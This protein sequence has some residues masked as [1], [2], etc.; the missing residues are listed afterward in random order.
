MRLEIL[1]AGATLLDPWDH[2]WGGTGGMWL[3][4]GLMM[5]FWVALVA[6]V[7]WLVATRSGPSPKPPAD[8]AREILAE[9]YARGEITGEEYRERLD[10]LRPG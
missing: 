2:G 5:L 6:A 4:G 3:W 9:R 7:V 10:T 1:A 8:S